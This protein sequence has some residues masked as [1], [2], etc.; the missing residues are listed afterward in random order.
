MA[1]SQEQP[2]YRMPVIVRAR[3]YRLYDRYNKRYLDLYQ[4]NGRAILGHR[5]ESLQRTLKSTISKGLL[6]EYPSVYDGRLE[7]IVKLMFTD[8]ANFRIYKNRERAM[9][10]I[11]YAV[12][13]GVSPDDF[14]D[15]AMTEIKEHQRLALWRPFL[16]EMT[17]KPDFLLPILPFPGGF[18][19]EVVCIKRGS[20]ADKM[21]P[22]DM[23]SPFLVDGLVKVLSKLVQSTHGINR[24]GSEFQRLIDVFEWTRRGPYIDTGLEQ[25][26]YV[27][28]FKRALNEGILLPPNE[29]NPI[30]IPR[31]FSEGELSRFTY[32]VQTLS[33]N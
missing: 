21:P 15:P 2:L 10:A 12:G 8:Y 23:V 17:V 27:E 24:E 13:K 6:A 29:K 26:A 9:V 14:A 5:I 7:K 31:E 16:P 32:F 4:N 30:I 25:V 19:P 22:S 3:G 28:L 18:V 33:G 11:S 20:L 1:K